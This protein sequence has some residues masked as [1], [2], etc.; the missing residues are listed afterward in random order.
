MKSCRIICKCILIT[1]LGFLTSCSDYTATPT[2]TQP[3]APQPSPLTVV[4]GGQSTSYNF[5]HFT[6]KLI[7]PEAGNEVILEIHNSFLPASPLLVTTWG[8]SITLVDNGTNADKVANDGVYTC[9]LNQQSILTRTGDFN[10]DEQFE[11]FCKK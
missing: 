9:K 2:Q 8:Q 3:P 11:Y 10:Y 1:V 6:P 7:T 5:Y 4:G